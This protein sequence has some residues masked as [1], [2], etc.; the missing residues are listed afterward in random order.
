LSATTNVSAQRRWPRCRSRGRRI[1]CRSL[2]RS[3]HSPG[4]CI[5]A[6][7][8]SRSSRVE[9]FGHPRS[10]R[11]QPVCPA[12]CS[13]H[14]SRAKPAWTLRSTFVSDLSHRGLDTL[15]SDENARA[16]PACSTGSAGA[17]LVQAIRRNRH[18]K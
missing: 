5:N 18:W 11:S 6:P 16:A 15:L 12:C 10:K 1:S 8:R 2:L 14:P 4:G 17:L 3:G 13:I 7:A 9:G